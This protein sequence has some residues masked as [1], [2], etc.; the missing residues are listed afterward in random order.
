[1]FEVFKK[2]VLVK[3]EFVFVIKK[4]EVLLEKGI[5]YEEKKYVFW[6]LFEYFNNF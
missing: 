6:M 5:Y 1:M 3:K 4:R 2:F